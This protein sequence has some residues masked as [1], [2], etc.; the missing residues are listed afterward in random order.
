M[1]I[2]RAAL[3]IDF[4][5]TYTKLRA[6]DLDRASIIG[7][8]Q[9]PSTVT[10]DINIGLD[11]A[12]ADLEHQTGNLPDFVH[13][14]A[15][16]SAAGGLGMVTIGLV[17]KLTAQAARHAALG[18]GA[19]LIGNYS[20]ELTDLDIS[21]IEAQRPDMILLCGGTDGGNKAIY[22]ENATRLAASKLDCP[23]VLAGNRSASDAAR[24]SLCNSGKNAVITE[25]V[26]P[27][28]L[29]L[30]IEPAR[31]V[32]REIFI[33]HIVRAKGIDLAASRFDEVLMPT[34]AAVLDATR[35]LADGTDGTPGIGPLM[36]LDIGGATTDVHSICDG[37]PPQSSAHFVGLEEPYAKRTVEG[38]LGM[39]HTASDVVAAF[40]GTEKFAAQAAMDS[41][42]VDRLLIRCR[43]EVDWLPDSAEARAFDEALSRAAVE[44]AVERHAGTHSIVQTVHGPATVQ[45]GK[46]LTQIGTIIGTGGVLVHGT[47]SRAALEGALWS[48]VRPQ[49][50]CPKSAEFFLDG[51]Y[52]LYAVG[53]LAAREPEVAL[54]LG[55]QSLKSL[56]KDQSNG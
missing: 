27:E 31:E 22:L 12:L 35:L 19:K 4:G 51:D 43:D 21:Q 9:G 49:S 13:T 34:P 18:A 32:I 2:V 45:R 56:S 54:A 50:L 36:L 48:A 20:Y 53:L 14:L 55:R 52:A 37:L 24:Q 28:Y 8:G 33:N 10:T 40:G 17:P 6:V 7:S 47:G 46:D 1:A 41:G 23:I 16:S 26:M 3:L 38:D 5:S 30:N 44:V 25:N 42:V 29:K 11:K 15:S 39:R